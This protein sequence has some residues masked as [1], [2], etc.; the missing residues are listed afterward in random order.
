MNVAD[1]VGAG[2]SVSRRGRGSGGVGRRSSV[3]RGRRI[4]GVV[5]EG[6]H[7]RRRSTAV[8]RCSLGGDADGGEQRRGPRQ[9]GGGEGDLA[10][11]GRGWTRVFVAGG[12]GSAAVGR[13]GAGCEARGVR[14]GVG[15]VV[16]SRVGKGVEACAGDADRRG[17]GRQ[18]ASSNGVGDSGGRMGDS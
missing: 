1:A 11:L 7:V 14:R 9:G 17:R 15:K 13:A 3:Y 12:V 10:R 5:G 16:G 6:G 8:A 4:E 18:D 2:G